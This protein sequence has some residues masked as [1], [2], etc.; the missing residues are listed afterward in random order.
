MEKVCDICIEKN[1]VL[2]LT[3]NNIMVK[4]FT[5]FS[6]KVSPDGVEMADKLKEEI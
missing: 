1:V 2:K 3:K 5:F 4:E 6:F